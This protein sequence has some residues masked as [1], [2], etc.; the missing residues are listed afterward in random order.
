MSIVLL[1]KILSFI[2]TILTNILMIILRRYIAITL[3]FSCLSLYSQVSDP[4][5]DFN[6]V[7]IN[8]EIPEVGITSITQDEKGII[9]IGTLG[10]GLYSFDGI[11]YSEYKHVLNDTTTLSSNM[12]R[13]S[14]VDSKDRLWVATENGLNLY[15]RDKN[16]FSRIYLN[17]K[18]PSKDYITSIH[19]DSRNNLVIGTEA[20]G[21]F[22][23]RLDDFSILKLKTS[24]IS[25]LGT[26]ISVKSIQ[27]THQGKTYVATN[28]GLKEIDY[29]NNSLIK[30]RVFV[31]GYKHIEDSIET[32]FV[33]NLGSLWIGFTQEKGIYKCTLSNDSSN[34]IEAIT[35]L[36]ITSKKIMSIVQLSDTSLV[37]GT[38]NDGLFHLDNEGKL[39]RSYK[40]SAVE[41]GGLLHNSVWELFVDR[42]QRLWL[43]Y[44]NSGIAVYDKLHDKFLHL[45]YHPLS[46]VS[47][48]N[49]SVT[50]VLEPKSNEVWIA[51][52]GG[53]IDVWNSKSNKIIHINKTDNS[54]YKGLTSN[55]ILNLFKD[56]KGNIWAGSWDHGVY[57]LK[58]GSKTFKNF[59][60]STTNEIIKD[61]AIYSFAEDSDGNVWI[62]GFSEGL[63]S[64]NLKNRKFKFHGDD[65]FKSKYKPHGYL[66]KILI[67]KDNDLWVGTT[68][69][70]YL[71]KLNQGEISKINYLGNQMGELYNNSPDA[72]NIL[73][74]YEG[75][76]KNIWIGTKGAG[77]C[78][79]NKIEGSFKW[80]NSTNGLLESNV[81][82][83]IQDLDNN[84]WLIGNNGLTQYD[85]KMNEFKNYTVSDGLLSNNFNLNAI[86]KDK[87]GY[88]FLGNYKGLD[89]F[90]PKKLLLNTV[91]PNVYLSDFKLYNESVLPNSK[92]SPLSKVISETNK[93]E[94]NDNQSVFTINYSAVNYT[95]PNKAKY[96]YFLE[97]Y[98]SAWNY[99]GS[100]RSATY[101]NLDSGTY[102]FKV[103]ATN[104][105]GVWNETPLELEIIVK[106]SWWKTSY[107]FAGYLLLFFGGLSLL[108]H[109]TRKRI[110]E[111]EKLKTL[112]YQQEKR[113][114]LHQKKLQFFTNISHEF[115]TPLTL[116]LN[117]IKDLINNKEIQLPVEV[118]NK[119]QVI[120]K[121]T[122]R[123]Y[124]LINE[125]MDLRKMEL[126]KMKLKVE[127]IDFYAFLK[128]CA[129]YFDQEIED[130]NILFL[131]ETNDHNIKLWADI[132]LLEKIVFNLFSNALKVTP[133]GG[134]INIEVLI[135]EKMCSFPLLGRLQHGISFKISD[136]G[137]GIPSK[138]LNHIFERFYQLESLNKS[139][140]GGTGIG[141]ELVQNSV[142]LH[143]GF[144]DVESKVNQGTTFNI[145]FPA[146]N[147]HFNQ[148]EIVSTKTDYSTKSS[149]LSV[150]MEEVKQ[151]DSIQ[152][153]SV[154]KEHTILIVEDN[155]ELREYLQSELMETYKILQASDGAE[156]FKLAKENFPDLIIS[157]VMMSGINGFDFCKTLKNKIETSHIPILLLTAK[158]SIENRIEGLESGADAY[159]VKPFDIKLLKIRISQLIN[160][161]KLIFDKYFSD[162]SGVKELKNTASVDKV[163][164]EKILNYINDNI[165][166]PS[167]SIEKL[168]S[169]LGLSRSQLYRKVK[170]L[171]GHSVNEFVRRTRLERAKQ[172]LESG[173]ANISETC[174]KVGFASP[175]YFSKC[176]RNHFGV[177][178]TSIVTKKEN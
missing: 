40:H 108:N 21:T 64:Y 17:R 140:I 66:K 82:G 160:S 171:T 8:G 67:D 60:V 93:I 92:K 7:S 81:S 87:K 89:Y 159:M 72:N 158:A 94:L 61:N 145:T 71:L 144:I 124:R 129:S 73:T 141:L 44:Y 146:G 2:K 43:G 70:L 138:E 107:A 128:N 149:F 109:L 52:D 48:K 162:I 25:P 10:T 100:K 83:I 78:V 174:Y 37:F 47:L 27:Q 102:T 118:K 151:E 5:S 77:L 139:S 4:S 34:I 80:Y 91:P 123:M 122:E 170:S 131:L 148:E 35:P 76:S 178:P 117:P 19:Q 113:N 166:D 154:K 110:N 68:N 112:R 75:T 31:D 126:N 88:L 104:N 49:P 24:E 62:G 51:T 135:S 50:S 143:K 36:T 42:D 69:G 12:V 58:K 11:E 84:I 55:Y 155:I 101:T 161:R 127:E 90:N 153:K 3:L 14:L 18:K 65:V 28:Y 39:I 9:W 46:P 106:P 169:H 98:E 114:E 152:H 103:K 115:R 121:N 96:A 95:R 175:S 176:F 63:Y 125:L 156:G 173:S 177:L 15:N 111:K 137:P 79:F 30:S 29:S 22:L 119:H 142:K 99:V 20:A 130:K 165:G 133:N 53:G 136:T 54:Y 168:A 157:D 33:D 26:P 163:F 13:A 41:E 105:D 147:L 86:Y 120:Y 23:L 116:I 32:L 1:S 150:P 6:F 97:G 74:L 134:T 164:V 16:T 167:L 132:K 59:H 57:F 56:S 172:I 85:L 45:K 38:E